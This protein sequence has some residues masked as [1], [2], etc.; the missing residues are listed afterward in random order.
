MS[1]NSIG[2]LFS[3]STFGES[4]GLALGCVVD[5]CPPGIE[6]T[7]EEIASHPFLKSVDVSR[8]C[9]VVVTSDRGLCGAFNTNIIK[10]GCLHKE[11]VIYERGLRESCRLI[12]MINWKKSFPYMDF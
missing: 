1:G 7:E 12:K 2:K 11:H 5:G 9:V 4:H 10:E 6:I 8:V 3:V